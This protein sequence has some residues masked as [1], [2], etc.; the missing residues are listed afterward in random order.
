MLIY[1]KSKVKKLHYNYWRDYTGI[2]IE[3]IDGKKYEEMYTYEYHDSNGIM[4]C[5][6]SSIYVFAPYNSH[7]NNVETR[8]Y[9]LYGKK[10]YQM[11]LIKQKDIIEFNISLY[12]IKYVNG[13]AKKCININNINDKI[14]ICSEDMI[15]Q[16]CY[17]SKKSDTAI[18]SKKPWENVDFNAIFKSIKYKRL[19]SMQLPE[20]PC[21]KISKIE[22][23]NNHIFDGS[24]IKC[25]TEIVGFIIGTSKNDDSLYGIPM[26][27]MKYLI[28]LHTSSF[29]IDKLG[30]ILLDYCVSNIDSNMVDNTLYIKD[31]YGLKSD[32]IV[33]KNVYISKINND[34][35]NSDGYIYSEK[36]GC[37]MKIDTYLL[38][39]NGIQNIL[40]EVL[41]NTD[42]GT[43]SKVTI[44]PYDYKKYLSVLT[45]D[46]ERC[47]VIHG[48]VFIEA[49][50]KILDTFKLRP[51]DL[52]SVEDKHH[53]ILVDIL[54]DKIDMNINE[55][56]EN[57]KIESS[58]SSL[59]IHKINNQKINNINDIQNIKLD[60]DLKIQMI[61]I[62][63]N[64]KKTILKY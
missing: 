16:S 53:F 55:M 21:Y 23:N 51:K 45:T 36:Y 22:N 8:G 35:I 49:H 57:E 15:I 47:I 27:Y 4:I 32:K 11:D 60:G 24:L 64:N 61:D 33:P 31:N 30:S 59:K 7:I 54:R 41:Y 38:L 29:N 37:N 14:D 34:K 13:I 52:Y 63:D 9:I 6:A 12:K 39:H 44:T 28:N 10:L 48:L 58:L 2:P 17:L 26:S 40:C 42:K 62:F 5:D 18:S 3:I 19:G 25:G 20:I 46:N 56:Y 43:K 1:I 50:E